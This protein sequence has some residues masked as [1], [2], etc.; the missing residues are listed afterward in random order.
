[1][2]GLDLKPLHGLY[3]LL[4]SAGDADLDH[5]LVCLAQLYRKPA[6][7]RASP[8]PSQL[9]ELEWVVALG[10]KA[11][12][13]VQK[14]KKR[15]AG[16]MVDVWW[17]SR[18]CGREVEELMQ[19]V[20]GAAL[21]PAQVIPKVRERWIEGKLEVSGYKEGEEPR[22]GIELIIRITP[23]LPLSI[24]L[25]PCDDAP[26][27]LMCI[28]AETIHPFLT[29]SQDRITAANA[30]KQLEALR[31]EHDKACKLLDDA[32]E[33]RKRARRVPGTQ[34]R[35]YSGDSNAGAPFGRR[36][37][38][39]D[40]SQSQS[41]SQ[42]FSYGAPKQLSPT[43]EKELSVS[44]TKVIPG[45]TRRGFLKPGDPG[46]AGSSHRPGRVVED[47]GW[48]AEPPSSNEE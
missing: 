45:V 19:Q 46:Y 12:A 25:T 15:K 32:R 33:D 16:G 39:Q 43:E 8:D 29:A 41:Q 1:M 35:Q 47:G 30:K 26:F 23:S 7:S 36:K 42:G 44:P 18:L 14:G 3:Q 37:S 34:L 13:P 11:P 2:D 10:S 27:S 24:I 31:T 20:D 22:G 38:S 40:Q 9:G 17:E 28:L 21:T 5:P 6:K 48:D 4:D